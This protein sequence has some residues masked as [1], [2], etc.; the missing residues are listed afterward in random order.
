MAPSPGHKRS[1]ANWP[2]TEYD[3]YRM[4]I[5][6]WEDS[7]TLLLLRRSVLL[8]WCESL[9]MLHI[10]SATW[11]ART[12]RLI[13]YSGDVWFVVISI[14]MPL[15]KCLFPSAAFLC[16]RTF[17]LFYPRIYLACEL[18]AYCCPAKYKTH[19]FEYNRGVIV[20]YSLPYLVSTKRCQETES[21]GSRSEP[22]EESTGLGILG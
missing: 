17:F 19:C 6:I 21:R 16:A 8:N 1:T 13:V 22:L 15:K 11:S 20:L 18:V 3:H 9:C 12:T 2:V 10:A 4:G 5:W 14:Q 7:T